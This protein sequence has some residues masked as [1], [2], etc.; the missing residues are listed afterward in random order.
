LLSEY[1]RYYHE[2]ILGCGREPRTTEFAPSPPG[3]LFLRI[4]WAGSIIV[5]IGLPDPDQLPAGPGP[6]LKRTFAL[7]KVTL[8]RVQAL[9][10]IRGTR[11][12]AAFS[13]RMRF[14]RETTQENQMAE[15]TAPPCTDPSATAAVPGGT[16]IVSRGS[17]SQKPQIQ[18]PRAIDLFH[19]AT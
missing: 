8:N 1:V 13:T 18:S 15:V 7:L 11:G 12:I 14:W 9:F 16:P 4:D 6:R 2:D 19:P 5:T 10:S 3:G 17:S